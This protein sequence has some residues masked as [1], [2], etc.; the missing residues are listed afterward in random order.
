MD[1]ELHPILQQMSPSSQQL[2]PIQSR[3]KDIVV[4]AGAG[5]GKTRTLVARFLSLLVDGVPLRSI[6]AITFTKKAARE[7]RNRIRQEVRHYLQRENHGRQ[8]GGWWQEVYDGLD[9]ARISTIHTLCAE[10]LRNHPAECGV[11]PAFEM[12]EEGQMALYQAQVVDQALGWAID[13]EQTVKLFSVFGAREMRYLLGRLMKKRLDVRS[14]QEKNDENLWPTWKRII[15]DPIL[16]FVEDPGVQQHFQSLLDLE[17][18]GAIQ[19]AAAKD[20]ALV[21]DLRQVLDSWRVIQSAKKE[22]DWIRLSRELNPLRESLKQKGRKSNWE[23]ADPKADIKYLQDRFDDGLAGIVKDG[24][25]LALDQRLA[26]DIVPAL[27]RVFQRCEEIYARKKSRDRLLDFDDLEW[28]AVR[29]LTEN[30][31]V[32]LFWQKRIEAI[33]V[34][35]FQDTNGRQRDLL[36]LL[37][38]AQGELF[39]VG[40]GKQS[41]YRFRGAD[42]A[43]F[44]EE[45]K[46]IRSSGKGYHL[47]TSYRAHKKLISELNTLLAPVLKEEPQEDYRSP[48]EPLEPHRDK[49][50]PGIEPPFVEFHLSVGKKSHGALNRA[51][52]A[53]VQRAVE[54]VGSENGLNGGTGGGEVGYGDIAVLCRSSG[55]FPA[56]ENALEEAGVPYLTI[57]GRGFYERPEVRDI[58]NALGAIADPQDDLAMCGLLRSPV[59]GLSDMALYRLR[60]AQKRRSLPSIYKVLFEEDLS[61]LGGEQSKIPRI[62][63]NIQDMHRDVGRI[64]VARLMRNF[65]RSTSYLSA[66]ERAGLSRGKENV[67]KLLSDA[68]QSGMVSISRFLSYV[69]ELRDV[70]IREGEA[71]ALAAGAVQIMTVHQ[72]KGL[73]FPIVVIGDVSR[74]TPRMRDVIIDDRFGVVPPI[75]VEKLISGTAEQAEINKMGSAVYRLAVK[76]ERDQEDAESDRLLYVAATRAKEKLLLSGVLGGIKKD[77]TPYSLQGW[78]EKL[79]TPLGLGDI[80]IPYD[81]E[82]GRIHS[83]QIGKP[84]TPF[85]SYIYEPGSFKIKQVEIEKPSLPTA[86]PDDL[87]LLEPLRAMD[88]SEDDK[89]VERE[90]QIWRVV[91]RIDYPSAPA[92]LIGKLVHRVISEWMFPTWER[93]RLRAWVRREAESSGLSG[94]ANTR[95]A[96]NKT[97]RLLD[98]FRAHTL[99]AEM[100]SAHRRYHEI[101]YTVE[102]DGKFENGVIDALYQENGDWTLVEFKTDRITS[103]E[104]LENVLQEKDYLEQVRSYLHVAEDMLGQRPRPVLCFLNYKQDVKLVQDR[105]QVEKKIG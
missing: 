25:D 79:G 98:Q 26:D 34:D 18:Q 60:E 21:P 101:P 29:M 97:M 73:E 65:L 61:F 5:T 99:F 40:D 84:S 66:M 72:A 71:P 28:K 39:I 46:A 6:L 50:I 36:A 54:I 85:P 52:E 32:R 10:I 74:G 9:A 42:V 92:W 31:D 96:V 70:S 22:K 1:Q 102:R 13:V 45:E 44:Q 77:G 33:L 30:K 19:E 63:A 68:Q 83:F 93:D 59:G 69:N 56:Y 76:R 95:G 3:G 17:R 86:I 81:P 8:D 11:D 48:F 4:T 67:R 23:P 49:A 20:D 90:R 80:Q 37:T 38:G 53:V 41:I 100:R 75:T 2:A 57:S 12:I 78:L 64:P 89:R 94:D 16:D 47:S 14:A 27:L 51:A 35:E 88:R 43:V 91:P 24:L 105:W 87:I 58:L 82:G 55:S 15:L 7:M 103:D 104:E 62:R